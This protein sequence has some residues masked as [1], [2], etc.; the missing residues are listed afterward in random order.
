MTVDE[1]PIDTG[2]TTIECPDEGTANALLNTIYPLRPVEYD[3]E[4][5]VYRV[6]YDD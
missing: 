5:D 2:C 6:G 3:E 4:D 1:P